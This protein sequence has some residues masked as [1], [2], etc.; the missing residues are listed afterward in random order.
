MEYPI[1]FPD[2]E[3]AENDG[4]V[5]VGGNLS[6]E[7]LLSAYSQG[8]FPWYN[9]GEPILWWCP[10]PRMILYPNKFI[11]SKSLR[12]KIHSGNYEIR[13]D[14][15]FA[16]VISNCAIKKRNSQSGTWITTD[17]I[18]A[19]TE[20]HRLGYAHS[21]ETYIDGKLVGGLYGIGLGKAFFGESMFYLARDASKLALKSLC[22]MLVEWDFHF[23]D[24]QQ[25]T[26][27][28]RSLGAIDIER[29]KFLKMLKRA[30]E[31]PTTNDMWKNNR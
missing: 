26:S 7:Y 12:Q 31:Y 3:L 14:T 10:N 8:L 30:L 20:L 24:V 25:S 27:H 18:N 28:L 15:D 16:S 9:E 23:I 13:F 22:E 2:P 4:L 11:T 17:I 19:Y 21:V 1:Q 6:V 5:A 29:S